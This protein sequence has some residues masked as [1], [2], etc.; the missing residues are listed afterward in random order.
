M[1]LVLFAEEKKKTEKEIPS[2][3]RAE[4]RKLVTDVIA[5]FTI[6]FLFHRAVWDQLHETRMA[7]Q[8]KRSES[9]GSLIDFS[10]RYAAYFDMCAKL[11]CGHVAICKMFGLF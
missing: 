1:K 3:G 11:R 7:R 10:A 5:S 4:K 6:V 8:G 2:S 9:C